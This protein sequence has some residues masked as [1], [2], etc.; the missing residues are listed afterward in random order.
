M[1]KAAIKT[2]LTYLSRLILVQMQKTFNHLCK[3]Y[4]YTFL[5]LCSLTHKKN[6]EKYLAIFGQSIYHI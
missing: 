1:I 2:P 5:I 4:I 6:Q 3:P